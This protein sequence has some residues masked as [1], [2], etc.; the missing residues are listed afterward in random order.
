MRAIVKFTGLAGAVVLSALVALPVQ[1]Q[2]EFRFAGTWVGEFE[3]ETEPERDLADRG[4]RDR[5]IAGDDQY[6]CEGTWVIQMRGPNDN[7]RMEG[8]VEQQ[9]RAR[10]SGLRQVPP[11]PI[12]FR[13]IEFEDEG[14]GEEKKLKF[15]MDLIDAKTDDSATIR[16]QGE[17]EYKPDDDKIEGDYQCRH[18]LRLRTSSRDL[19]LRIRGEFELVRQGTE[20]GAGR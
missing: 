7:L 14:E 20:T 6:E 2:D 9:C 18:T 10:R 8:M 16:C 1:A 3:E 17:M 19:A 12:V 5:A 11:N 4:R 15:Q 13:D